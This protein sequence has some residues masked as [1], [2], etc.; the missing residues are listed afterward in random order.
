MKID[1][2]SFV[3]IFYSVIYNASKTDPTLLFIADM[4]QK[5]VYLLDSISVTDM[6]TPLIQLLGN[7]DFDNSSIA[8]NGWNQGCTIEVGSSVNQSCQHN[9]CIQVHTKNSAK[10]N[11]GLCQEFTA[12]VGQLYNISFWLRHTPGNIKDG[13]HLYVNII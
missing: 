11:Y 1:N 10:I 8:L 4:S 13:S 9:S 7:A 5:D 2:G 3:G 6:S 12:T